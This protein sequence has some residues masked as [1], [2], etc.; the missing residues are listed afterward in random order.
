MI[1][2]LAIYCKRHQGDKPFLRHAAFDCMSF[3][4]H[5]MFKKHL[6]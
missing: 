5:D 4:R 2:F 3:E 6:M 1:S